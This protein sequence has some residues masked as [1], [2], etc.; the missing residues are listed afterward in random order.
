MAVTAILTVASAASAILSLPEPAGR[1]ARPAPQAVEIPKRLEA[2][3]ATPPATISKPGRLEQEFDAPAFGRYAVRAVSRFGVTLHLVDAMTGPGTEEGVLGKRDGRIDVFLDPGRH[4]AALTLPDKADGPVE[5]KVEPFAERNETP[6]ALRDLD[7]VSTQLQDLEQRSYWI[8]V[9]SRRTVF[10]EAAGRRLADLRLWKDGS[11]LLAAEPASDV[12]TPAAGQPLQ[13]MRL[14][15]DLQPGLYRLTAYGGPGMAWSTESSDNPLHVRMGIPALGEGVRRSLVAGP[16]GVDRWLVPRAANGFRLE[17][18]EPGE[19]AMDVSSNFNGTA[20]SPGERASIDKKTRLRAADLNVVASNGST[21]VSV[22]RAAGHPYSLQT[23]NTARVRTFNGPGWHALS[24]T[25]SGS[26]DDVDLGAILVRNAPGGETVVASRALRLAPETGWMRR[27]NLMAPLSMFVE[28]AT[29]GRYSLRTENVDAELG[30]EPFFKGQGYKPAPT[31]VNAGVWDLEAGFHVVTLRPRPEGRGIAT[32]TIQGERAPAA[33]QP[34]PPVTGVD[35]PKLWLESDRTYRLTL[36]QT[37]TTSGAQLRECLPFDL[38]AGDLAVLLE[39][40][41]T[42]EV[43]ARVKGAGTIDLV[44]EDGTSLPLVV[45]GAAPASAPAIGAGMH[46]LALANGGPA[47]RPAVLRFLPK[48]TPPSEPPPADL[49]RLPRFPLLEAGAPQFLDLGRTRSSTFAVKVDKPALYRVESTGLLQT[50]GN[51]RTQI[52]PTVVRASANGTGRNFLLQQYLRPGLYQLT[53]TTEGNSA[54]HLGLALTASEVR[55]AGALSFGTPARIS[56]NAGEA[57][58]YDLDVTKPGTYRLEALTLAGPTEL[59]LEDAG[60]W[61]LT[62][63]GRSGPLT[64]ELEPGRYRLVVLPQPLPA[65]IVTLAEALPEPMA[66]EGHGPHPLPLDQNVTHRWEEPAEGAERMPDTWAFTLPAEADVDITLG[67]GMEGRLERPDGTLVAEFNHLRP[68][69]RQLAAGPWRLKTQSIRPNNRLDYVISTRVR[70]LIAGAE[71]RISAP[72][73]LDVSVGEGGLVD[74][75]S[76][77]SQDVRATLS[78]AAGTVVA[79]ADDRADDWNFA[80]ATRLAPGTYKLTVEPVGS[81]AAQTTIRMREQREVQDTPLAAGS[82]RIVDDGAMHVMPLDSATTEELLVVA[83]RSTDEMGLAVERERSKDDWTVLDTAT[84]RTPHLAVARS[85]GNYRLRAWSL[86][87]ARTPLGVTA[88]RLTPA[89]EPEARLAAGIGLTPLA[90]TNIGAAAIR[91]DRPGLIQ[92]ENA[93]AGVTWSGSLDTRALAS[94]DGTLSSRDGRLWFVG[95]TNAVLKARRVLPPAE[96]VLAL[97]LPEG[98]EGAVPVEGGRGAQLW[99]AGSGVAQPGI[100]PA[101]GDP[102]A[103]GWGDGESVAVLPDASAAKGAVMRLWRASGAGALPLTLR[104]VLFPSPTRADL[105]VGLTDGTIAAGGALSFGLPKGGKRLSLT[106]P[107]ATAAALTEAGRVTATLWAGSAG[108]TVVLDSAADGLLLLDAGAEGRF[109]VDLS[110]AAGAAATLGRHGLTSRWLPTEGDLRFDVSFDKPATVQVS[111]AVEGARAVLRDGRVVEGTRLTLSGDATLTLRH[112]AGLLA[113][114]ADGEDAEAWPSASAAAPFPAVPGTLALAE[115]ALWRMETPQA[116]LLHLSTSNP[117]ALGHRQLDA[118]P[119]V[120]AWASGAAAHLFLPKGANVIG[121]KA[122]QEGPLG[123][124][125]RLSASPP[126]TI[127]EGLGAPVR[128]APG[129]AR[130]FTFTLPEPGPVGIGLRGGADTARARLLDEAGAVLGEGAVSMTK[131]AAG[132]YYLLVE[133]RADAPSV[134]VRPALVGSV[135]PDT[136]PPEDVKRRYWQMVSDEQEV[137]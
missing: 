62:N 130:L 4:K 106:L 99:L 87:H 44:A 13:A 107:P 92:L 104:R 110:P 119:Q 56:L 2:P 29:P 126:V 45:D 32:L 134:E 74:I 47:A 86:D 75:A 14:M 59:R 6:Q 48:P 8:D 69:G 123:G 95:P 19:A 79:R 64:R 120:A 58:A 94:A 46:V 127:A 73:T 65:R 67:E 54:G 109:A 28:V 98:E 132:R 82:E 10:I 63:P 18:P 30:V 125:A 133:N 128:L 71:R 105:E 76:F 17:L 135:R 102:R 85:A 5:L 78:D 88:H 68:F 16:F 137:R 101:E 50:E 83:G 23:F 22:E 97:T 33:A 90:G 61:P 57:V 122:L 51:M 26:G 49:A 24:V 100:A 25:S 129:D 43:S 1:P 131:L 42:R 52:R 136:G 89:A 115:G 3:P 38:E 116:T 36:N 39:P 20:M 70:Q 15:V 41:E 66:R 40:G 108:R 80:I 118:P 37:G 96:G 103:S 117:V 11:W 34:A 55:A 124:T 12:F 7:L 35:F 93:P 21:L 72:T 9:P 112:R 27:F 53:V 114:W 77:G 84:G 31:G 121:L 81:G 60:G 111:G 113:L 91:L